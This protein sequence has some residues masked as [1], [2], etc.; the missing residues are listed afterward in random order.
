MMAAQTNPRVASCHRIVCRCC[1]RSAKLLMVDGDGNGDCD[2]NDDGEGNGDGEGDGDG[3]G[4]A[5]GLQK[6]LMLMVMMVVVMA[7]VIVRVTAFTNVVV[8]DASMR[9]RLVPWSN[10]HSQQTFPLENGKFS[11]L[12]MSFTK[13]KVKFYFCRRLS[14]N[15]M[16]W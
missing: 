2:G 8:D 5:P 14:I 9:V 1:T 3:A 12:P 15:F 10:E 6:L 4:D 11:F 16:F 7:T 13:E